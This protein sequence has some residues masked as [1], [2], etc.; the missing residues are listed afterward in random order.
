MKGPELYGLLAEFGAPSG[1]VSAAHKVHEAGY[2][3]VDA[4]S[5]YAIEELSHALHHPPS[6]LPRIV[7]AGGLFV[8]LK[9][10]QS[11]R[12]LRSKVR[13]SKDRGR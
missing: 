12:S 8:C 1:V 7:L 3:R 2:T 6:P 13:T 10:I 4:Y 9:G 5:P 11:R